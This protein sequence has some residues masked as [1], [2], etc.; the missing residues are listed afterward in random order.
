MMSDLDS[1]TQDISWARIVETA[2]KNNDLL[3]E[4]VDTATKNKELLKEI[5]DTATSKN[6]NDD[7]ASSSV[8]SKEEEDRVDELVAHY[9]W[10]QRNTSKPVT[11]IEVV[12]QDKDGKKD[13]KAV[14]RDRI[15]RSDTIF[16]L[17]VV[18]CL[19]VPTETCC[20]LFFISSSISL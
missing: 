5:V 6:K 16:K 20:C 7:R 15:G 2:T 1:K 19:L 17:L 10:Q 11:S 13:N 18:R 3:A 4:M 9:E 12:Y 8:L 14:Q